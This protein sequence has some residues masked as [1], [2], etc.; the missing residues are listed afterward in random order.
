[1]MI[2]AYKKNST[3]TSAVGMYACTERGRG[4]ADPRPVHSV[5]P[6]HRYLYVLVLV[7]I[8][9]LHCSAD[10]EPPLRSPDTREVSVRGWL[11]A[12]PRRGSRDGGTWAC[13]DARAAERG[14][15]GGLGWCSGHR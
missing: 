11:P 1:M 10:A 9:S 2:S 3:A 14:V 7:V 12:P 4:F 13:G 6:C 15:H 8:L 5:R